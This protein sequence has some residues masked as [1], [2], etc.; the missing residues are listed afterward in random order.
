M[1][2]GILCSAK[3]YS[4]SLLVKSLWEYSS[5]IKE[6]RVSHKTIMTM[7]PC[8]GIV[9]R[10]IDILEAVIHNYRLFINALTK[11]PSRIVE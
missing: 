11:Y 1:M 8:G 3:T 7:T 5:F 10:L 4:N 2:S 6:F 9:G